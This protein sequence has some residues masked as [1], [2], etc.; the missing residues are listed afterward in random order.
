MNI[1]ISGGCKNGKSYY[2][3]KL[4]LSMAQE[5][6]LPLYYLATM[7]PVDDEEDV[8]KRQDLYLQE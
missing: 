6:S 3:Q 1:L 4:A 8:Y 7:I 2:A 5:K